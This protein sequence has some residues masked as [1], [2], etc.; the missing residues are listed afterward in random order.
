MDPGGSA[1]A[2][3][4]VAM[5]L[6]VGVPCA[7]GV[8]GSFPP[9]LPPLVPS[10]DASVEF[11]FT[12]VPVPPGIQHAQQGTEEAEQESESYPFVFDS[13]HRSVWQLPAKNLD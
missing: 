9:C 6:R 8:R 1:T 5:R 3:S 7:A 13:K 11:R 2:A 12:F 4:M 10:G